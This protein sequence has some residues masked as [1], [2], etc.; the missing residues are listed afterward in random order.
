MCGIADP[1]V[2]TWNDFSTGKVWPESAVAKVVLEER[3]SD[4]VN[5]AGEKNTFWL[6]PVKG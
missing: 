2:Q 1:P 3:M 6:R 4:F 5:Y